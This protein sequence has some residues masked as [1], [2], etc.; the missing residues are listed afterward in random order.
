M[1]FSAIIAAG[2][3]SVS[4]LAKSGY[5]YERLDKNDAVSYPAPSVTS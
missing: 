5:K 1:K 3:L 2:V 4:A